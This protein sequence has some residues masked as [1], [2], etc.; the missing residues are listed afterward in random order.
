LIAGYETYSF[1]DIVFG[2]SEGLLDLL[3][4]GEPHGQDDGQALVLIHGAALAIK[5]L[6]F[7][8]RLCTVVGSHFC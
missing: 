1:V 6:T 5:Q 3:D 8:S 4:V 2:E 7:K